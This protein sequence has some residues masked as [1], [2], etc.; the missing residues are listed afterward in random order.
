MRELL[1]DGDV[2]KLDRLYDSDKVH[3]LDCLIILHELLL[4]DSNFLVFVGS[5][6]ILLN[7]I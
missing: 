4:L 6:Q 3:P 7:H 5:E 1:F 2:V